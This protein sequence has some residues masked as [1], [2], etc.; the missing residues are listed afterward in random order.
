MSGL[1]SMGLLA[2]LPDF[3]SIEN[4]EVLFNLRFIHDAGFSR[5]EAQVLFAFFLDQFRVN[6]AIEYPEE[7]G[8]R[9]E[10]F[11]PKNQQGGFWKRR[12]PGVNAHPRVFSQGLASCRT[13]IQYPP[14]YLERVLTAT[15][16][17]LPQRQISFWIRF[18]GYYRYPQPFGQL[19]K[20]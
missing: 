4:R 15:R 3:A 10:F 1:E 16:V 14:D 5:E 6:R 19:Y 9:D 7:V 2:F 13:N 11:A 17:Y 12:P 18:S 8:P 20:N